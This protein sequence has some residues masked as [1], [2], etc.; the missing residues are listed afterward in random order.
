[1]GYRSRDILNEKIFLLAL[2]INLLDGARV[3]LNM[4]HQFD[5][6]SVNHLCTN[7]R[8]RIHVIHYSVCSTKAPFAFCA[9]KHYL[10]NQIFVMLLLVVR[11]AN[12]AIITTCILFA[13]YVTFFLIC[14]KEKYGFY[15]Q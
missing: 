8:A 12:C 9:H 1:M 13:P 6:H 10:I 5:S 11:I 7:Y 4:F 3:Q 2:F 15:I 14:L